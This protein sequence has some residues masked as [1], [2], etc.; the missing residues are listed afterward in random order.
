MAD[1]VTTRYIY[2]PDHDL[3]VSGD[4]LLYGRDGHQGGGFK[5]YILHLTNVSDG[6]GESKVRKVDLTD[7]VGPT[8]KEALRT[9]IEWIEYDIFGMDVILYWE[10]TPADVQIV[11][12]AGGNTSISGKI[13]GPLYDPRTGDGT[14]GT[15]DILL[16]TDNHSS[17]DT[18]NLRICFRCKEQTKPG[19][20]V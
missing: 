5:R 4:G 8:G 13:R 6:T 12:I 18:Y 2:P 20:E 3:H 7:H 17:E 10:T 19:I 14:D 15:G 16:S 9:V 11:R 1:A